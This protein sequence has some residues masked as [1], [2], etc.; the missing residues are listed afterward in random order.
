MSRPP[1]ERAGLGAGETFAQKMMAKLGWKEGQGIGKQD[2]ERTP[3]HPRD[4]RNNN[5][6]TRPEPSNP[7]VVSRAPDI[8]GTKV[9]LLTNMVGPGEVDDDLQTETAEECSKYGKVDRCIVFEVPNNQV[10]DIEAVRI[11]IKFHD[12]A[13][14]MR[15]QQELN[16]RFFGGRVVTATYFE[17]DRFDRLDLAPRIVRR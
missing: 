17:E 10:P 13:S 14:A 7:N 12:I 8:R 4:T 2:E 16:G 15:A 11:F 1:S 5:G 3:P 6:G 9:V